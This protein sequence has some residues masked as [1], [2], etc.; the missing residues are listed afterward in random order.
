MLNLIEETSHFLKNKTGFSPEIVIILGTG[1]GV[2]G[3]G[4][5]EQG[6]ISQLI[7]SKP[8]ELTHDG[9]YDFCLQYRKMC[10]TSQF[11]N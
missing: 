10:I 11:V 6:M 2:R 4:I 8:D 5:I 3:Y 7:E 1:L 9:D